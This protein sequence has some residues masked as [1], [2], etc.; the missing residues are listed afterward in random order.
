[1]KVIRFFIEWNKT[2]KITVSAA[3]A[4]HRGGATRDLRTNYNETR[5]T[6][7]QNLMVALFR[8]AAEAFVF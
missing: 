7:Q 5:R 6:G 2:I 4:Q 8:S 1:M 3:Y